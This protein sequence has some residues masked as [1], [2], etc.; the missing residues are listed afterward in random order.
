STTV[1]DLSINAGTTAMR[2]VQVK[3]L[4]GLTG[5]V[6]L[7]C[8][9]DGAPAGIACTVPASTTPSATGVTVNATIATT[10]AAVAAPYLVTVSGTNGGQT[11]QY[12]FTTQVRDYTVTADNSVSIGNIPTGQTDVVLNAFILTA[13]NGFNSSVGLSCV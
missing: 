10:S 7:S 6:A 12:Q 1:S 11:R 9:I 8:A 3:S 4:N 5:T 13:L 2:G